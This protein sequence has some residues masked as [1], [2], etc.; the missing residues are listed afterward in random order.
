MAST[1]TPWW[2]DATVYQIYPASFKDSNNDGIGDLGG[3]IQSLDYIQSLGVDAI[4]VCPMYASPQIDMG[5]DISDYEAVYPPYGTMEDMDTLISEVHRRDMR[6]ILDLVI[7]H[8]SDQHEWF[9]QSRSSKD[10]PKRD[11][12]MWRPAKYDADGTRH[13]PNNW[14]SNFGDSTWQWDELTQ[15]Y[16][17][18]LFCPEQPD[19]NWENVKTRQAIYQSAMISWLERG[20]DGFRVDTVNM[21]SKPPGLPDAPI[22]DPGSPW[23]DAGLVYCNGPHMNMY[24]EEMNAILAKYDAMSV[25]E[26]PFTP[27][28]QRVVDYVSTEKRRLNMVFQFDAVNVGIGNTIK[29][30]TKPFNYTLVDL[31]TAIAGTQNLLDGTDAWTTSFIENHDQAR[32]V[33]RFGDDSPQWRT[34]SAKMLAMLFGCLSGTLYLYQG[35]ELGMVN[36]PLSVSIEEYKDVDSSNYYREMVERSHNDPTAVQ[37][38]KAALQHLARDHARTPMQWTSAKHAGFTGPEAQPWMFVNSSAA[39]G[40]NVAHEAGDE[41][42]V[43]AFWRQTL[44]LRRQHRDVLVHGQF[45]L[46]DAENPR[47]FSFVKSAIHG[48]VRTLVVC[49]FSGSDSEL[50]NYDGLDL[51]AA[52]ALLGNVEEDGRYDSPRE[53]QRDS[54]LQPWESRLYIL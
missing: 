25:G 16:Y 7:N 44:K 43:L 14:R 10:N 35:Q 13:P 52:K 32:S 33:S 39:E 12:Y 9:K 24:L 2:K 41:F 6:I 38:A 37:K 18:H 1:Q 20:V 17:L 51:S 21:Y 47:V 40:I 28:R 49:N 54:R 50:P 45:D 36:L 19:L 22:K 27:D 29:F 23:Q 46:V 15:E 8:T 30:L 3:I 42:S 31:K 26:C 11:W 5:Y 53:G 34:R 4:W 48:S